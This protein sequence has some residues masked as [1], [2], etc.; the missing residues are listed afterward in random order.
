MK[1]LTKKQLAARRTA[2][3]GAAVS[4]HIT[5]NA[6]MPTT[7]LSNQIYDVVQG[8]MEWASSIGMN[9]NHILDSVKANWREKK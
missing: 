9:P 5:A 7:W 6:A 4:F 1:R 2:A 8:L 3:W